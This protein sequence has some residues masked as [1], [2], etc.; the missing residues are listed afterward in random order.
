[1]R[2]QTIIFCLLVFAIFYCQKENLFAQDLTFSQ[3]YEQP[4]LRNPALSG[5]FKGDIRVSGAYRD[6][7]SSIT[8]P[9]KTGAMSVEYKMP[10]GEHNDV[11]TLATQMTVDAAGDISLKRT[12]LLPALSFHKSLSD[13]KD[14]YLSVAFMGGPVFS[15]FDP[16]Q[17][18]FGDQYVGGSY[19]PSNPTSQT[20]QYTSYQYWDVATGVCFSS[21]FENGGRWYAGASLAHFNNPVIRSTTGSDATFLAPKYSLNI[22]VNTP[23]SDRNRMIFFGD[24]FAENGHRQILGGFLYGWDF[25][26]YYETDPFT[27]Y[28]GTF[29]RWG[30]AIIPV[31]KMDFNHLSIGISYDVNY[32][33]LK[34]ASNW[35]GGLELT[36][37][38]SNFLKVRN[39]TLDKVRCVAF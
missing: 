34:V 20:L 5:V 17:I 15:Q 14:T 11:F 38:Y 28:L 22:G 6:Q 32:S 21:Q 16:T 23:V 18:K 19:N 35:R 1:M 33:K 36:A 7:W 13:E 30:D 8:I 37:S 24:Y 27:L 3:F 26:K 25:Q 2:K 29:V 12:Q 39:S 10:V 31:V 9:F 4:L